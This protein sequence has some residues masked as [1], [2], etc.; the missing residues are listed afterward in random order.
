MSANRCTVGVIALWAALCVVLLAC[1]LPGA[2]GHPAASAAAASHESVG[3]LNLASADGAPGRPSAPAPEAPAADTPV[4]ADTGS[5]PEPSTHGIR[6]ALRR[7][8]WVA[9]V[10]LW[11]ADALRWQRLE[12]SLRLNPGHAPPYA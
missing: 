2:H 12:P 6:A 11:P 4:A 3:A 10:P 8:P 7:T 1:A 5:D 9:M